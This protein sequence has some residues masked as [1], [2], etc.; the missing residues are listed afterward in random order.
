MA[1]TITAARK[2]IA[3]SDALQMGNARGEVINLSG[4]V[5]GSDTGTYRPV[6]KPIML[7]T[8][9]PV[10]IGLPHLLTAVYS[11]STGLITFTNGTG[12]TLTGL[13]LDVLL[14]T[15]K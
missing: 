11:V 10:I 15:E 4:T 5:A 14:L 7:G 9:D 1:V 12:G 8:T 3:G 6:K 2:P 13:N